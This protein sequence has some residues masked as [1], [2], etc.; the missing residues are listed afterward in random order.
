MQARKPLAARGTPGGVLPGAHLA[1]G[2]NAAPAVPPLPPRGA[3][4]EAFL[5]PTEHGGL[6]FLLPL[7][8]RL[9]LPDWLPP[10]DG[11]FASLVLRTA[12][13]RLGSPPD[14]PAW[15]LLAREEDGRMAH[16][17][18]A[19]GRWNDPV[20]APLR[21]RPPLALRLARSTSAAGQAQVWLDAARYWMRRAGRMGL[22]T[23]VRRPARLAVTATHGDVFFDLAHADLQVR[24]LGLDLDPG[25]LPWFG[26]VVGFHYERN[27][28]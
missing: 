28:T 19:P 17:A 14:D 25:W 22:A 18:A 3:L 2:E 26:R 8:Q 7:L 12:L 4:G 20:L 13:R 6:L 1:D 24:R 21:G 10:D 27:E 16:P 11:T 9:G 23:L 15:L 5:E